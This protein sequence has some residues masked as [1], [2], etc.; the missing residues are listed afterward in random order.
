MFFF[1]LFVC[2]FQKGRKQRRK[3]SRAGKVLC[4]PGITLLAW[5]GV[6]CEGGEAHREL[7]QHIGPGSHSDANHV[8]EP[9]VEQGWSLHGWDVISH[10]TQSEQVSPATLSPSLKP[11]YLQWCGQLLSLS[12]EVGAR[13]DSPKVL[14]HTWQHGGQLLH[15]RELVPAGRVEVQ[16]PGNSEGTGLERGKG[17]GGYLPLREL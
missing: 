16:D 14:D 7:G 10:E 17:I 4:G 12:S 6:L 8:L 3:K 2:F 5:P 11:G 1:S 15:G 9:V 13:K